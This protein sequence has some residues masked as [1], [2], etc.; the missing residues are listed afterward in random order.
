MPPFLL[1]LLLS[2]ALK[3]G[4]PL[5]LSWLKEKFPKL[6]INAQLIQ[7]LEEHVEQH[8]ELKAETKR[9]AM[10]CLG[11]GCESGIVKE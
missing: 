10:E 8:D 2:L 5:V 9:K 3:W 7:V 4:I 6:P 1:N 11:V